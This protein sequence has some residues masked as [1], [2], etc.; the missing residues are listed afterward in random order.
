MN[1]KDILNKIT[2]KEL[3]EK[4]KILSEDIKSKREQLRAIRAEKINLK[5]ALHE[6]EDRCRIIETEWDELLEVKVEDVELPF[7]MLPSDF[8]PYFT[9]PLPFND[10]WHY[11]IGPTCRCLVFPSV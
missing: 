7:K 3:L 10:D 8:M 4:E 11:Q 5:E 9:R 6:A 2:E 1:G